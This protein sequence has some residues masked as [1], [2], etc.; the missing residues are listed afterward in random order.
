MI[1]VKKTIQF[2]PL[3]QSD[4]QGSG[5][6]FI[7]QE[8]SIPFNRQEPNEIFRSSDYRYLN[9]TVDY[10]VGENG[11]ASSQLLFDRTLQSYGFI[12]ENKTFIPLNI[13]QF[14]HQ[15]GGGFFS[16]QVLS[17]F[18]LGGPLGFALS[19]ILDKGKGKDHYF[20]VNSVCGEALYIRLKPRCLGTLLN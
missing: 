7:A 3:D 18:V 1:K 16:P 2:N 17:S 19:F 9:A 13:K 8:K 15:F 12:V 11:W 5:V 14:K 4:S 20:L 10:E 6:G